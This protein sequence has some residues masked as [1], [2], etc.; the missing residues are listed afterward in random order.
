LPGVPG[1]GEGTAHA[2]QIV[3]NDAGEL[4]GSVFVGRS[5]GCA[6]EERLSVVRR[7]Q[8]GDATNGDFQLLGGCLVWGIL[9]A[10]GELDC[11]GAKAGT[12]ELGEQGAGRSIHVNLIFR[13]YLINK[14]NIIYMDN[15]AAQS[16]NVNPLLLV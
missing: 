8:G 9:P 6:R 7:G 15:L 13:I 14:S 1:T 5:I 3:S 12:A 4:G 11:A 16:R 2:V 10:L